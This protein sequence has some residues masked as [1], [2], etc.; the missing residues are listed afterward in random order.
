MD[1]LACIRLGSNL[2]KN[3]IVDK[4]GF[5]H[6][7]YLWIFIVLSTGVC[8][9]F[10]YITDTFFLVL[11]VL[12]D[13]FPTWEWYGCEEFVSEAGIFTLRTGSA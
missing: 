4:I 2:D 1:G 3:W 10:M 6:N 8:R 5:I 11:V 12:P 13:A 9:H 7:R